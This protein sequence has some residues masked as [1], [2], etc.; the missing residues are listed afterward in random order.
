MYD[1]CVRDIAATEDSQ[2]VYI[3]LSGT[4][5]ID[6]NSYIMYR[7]SQI[8]DID[9]RCAVIV[10]GNIQRPYAMITQNWYMWVINMFNILAGLR[11]PL[12]IMSGTCSLTSLLLALCGHHIVATSFSQLSLYLDTS[13]IENYKVLY[14]TDPGSAQTKAMYKVEIDGL[15]K[16][17]N[18]I[19]KLLLQRGA[20]TA[21]LKTISHESLRLLNMAESIQLKYIDLVLD[22]IHN[23][24][25]LL[26]QQKE[27]AQKESRLKQDRVSSQMP[28]A[29]Q[30]PAG[31]N[32]VPRG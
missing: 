12:V 2:N 23:M 30:R 18:L 27:E 26:R 6:C 1:G 25:G 11:H 29:S 15:K 9:Q 31:Q 19:Y 32:P 24:A 10:I 16:Y 5:T 21:I 8:S 4:L 28:G 20:N 17:T 22:N 7:L 13:I 3:L 14:D